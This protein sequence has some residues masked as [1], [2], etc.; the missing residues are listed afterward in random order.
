M[1]NYRK[2]FICLG[3]CI[4]VVAL[5]VAAFIHKTEWNGHIWFPT[6]DS[7]QKIEMELKSYDAGVSIAVTDNQTEI[8]AILAELSTSRKASLTWYS[9]ANDV[10]TVQEYLA[11]RV[12]AERENA[13]F[14]L[15][16][17]NN[18]YKIYAPYI[19]IYKINQESGWNIHQVFIGL[20]P[21]TQPPR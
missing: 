15:Y 17:E 3:I 9:T 2:V 21:Q 19:G 14:Y 16:Y 5:I 13:T 8:N 20:Q 4:F 6:P 12:Y 7:V 11:V 10:P 18:R 1:K